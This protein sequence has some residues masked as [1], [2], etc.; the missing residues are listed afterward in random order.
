MVLIDI[1]MPEGCETCPLARKSDIVPDATLC[2][3]V[4]KSMEGIGIPPYCPLHDNG[5]WQNCPEKETCKNHV[6]RLYP[7]GTLCV[8][9]P[10]VSDVKRVFVTEEEGNYGTLYYR[11][12]FV[13]FL[14]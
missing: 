13:E 3:A 2:V 6:A 14:D 11:D 4:G 1:E 7:D 9:T 10:R 5:T 12:I 8:K